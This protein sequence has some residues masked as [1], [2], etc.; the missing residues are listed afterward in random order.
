MLHPMIHEFI[1][2]DVQRGRLR[3]AEHDR[4][5]RLAIKQR[6]ETNA[7]DSHLSWSVRT[8]AWLM[9]Q[10]TWPRWPRHAATPA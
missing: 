6:D 1:A 4:Q 9:F 10:L 5:V 7:R 3:A 8:Q 2:A